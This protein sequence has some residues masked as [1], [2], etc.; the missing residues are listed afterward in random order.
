MTYL[1]RA[2]F[3]RVF[4]FC[5]YLI[6][7]EQWAVLIIFGENA[8]CAAMPPIYSLC[9]LVYRETKKYCIFPSSSL[10]STNFTHNPP[11]YIIQP[12]GSPV[13]RCCPATVNCK[14]QF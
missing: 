5:L 13:Q 14:Q 3:I 7:R 11:I 8:H 4:L 9:S 1:P 12:C 6:F 2:F 10:E